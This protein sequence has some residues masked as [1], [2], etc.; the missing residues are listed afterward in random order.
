[1]TEKG[2]KEWVVRLPWLIQIPVIDWILWQALH[3]VEM[4]AQTHGHRRVSW[5]VP[6]TPT[7]AQQS[8][9]R[10]QAKDPKSATPVA[11]QKRV[12][13][14]ANPILKEEGRNPE[15]QEQCWHVMHQIDAISGTLPLTQPQLFKL[16][17]K[18]GEEESSVALDFV[19]PMP[20]SPPPWDSGP[21]GPYLQPWTW[22][23][24]GTSLCL[25]CSTQRGDRGDWKSG[26]IGCWCFQSL[27][28]SEIGFCFPISYDLGKAKHLMGSYEE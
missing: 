7:H 13:K 6:E 26:P 20:P 10:L 8:Q 17:V 15:L 22:G 28:L 23:G 27:P 1:M 14:S 11:S 2:W 3:F 12:R 9:A 5:M 18:D 25:S 19:I 21:W 16:W 24:W 4:P